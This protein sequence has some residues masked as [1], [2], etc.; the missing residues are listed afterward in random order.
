MKFVWLGLIY[1]NGGSFDH[2][3][4]MVANLINIKNREGMKNKEMRI[5]MRGKVAELY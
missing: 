2:G 1:L 4:T 3:R 5:G